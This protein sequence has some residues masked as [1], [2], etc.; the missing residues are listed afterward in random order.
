M[1]GFTL[2]EIIYGMNTRPTP[3]NI[4]ISLAELR[5]RGYD[6]FFDT[7]DNKWKLA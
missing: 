2:D 6:A 4:R 3:H 7:Y 1:S 5:K